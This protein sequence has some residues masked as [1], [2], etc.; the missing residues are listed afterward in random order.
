MLEQQCYERIEVSLKIRVT[1]PGKGT[2]I[3]ITRYISDSE[4]LLVAD[5]D[6]VPAQGTEMLLQLDRLV[7]DQD[8]PVVRATVVSADGQ[9]IIFR[10]SLENTG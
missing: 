5:F 9:E 6:E 1:W 8:P 10:F 7:L 4:T 3:G 2:G